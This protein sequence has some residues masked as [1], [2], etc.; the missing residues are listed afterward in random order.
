M[1]A[2]DLS[3]RTPTFGDPAHADCVLAVADASDLDALREWC[4]DLPANAYGTVFVEVFAPMQIVDL[5]APRRVAVRWICREELSP[6]PR[7]GIGVPR[8][9]ALAS[10]VG[11]WFDEWLGTD[12]EA[13][14]RYLI[15]AGAR[16]TPIMREFW[17]TRAVAH[18]HP[19][20]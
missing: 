15:W 5:Q 19:Q 7:P 11:A 18:H 3:T 9:Q 20:A 14:D 16:S 10:A 17:E 6:S 1:A 4:A 12:P 2:H 8:G 13:A